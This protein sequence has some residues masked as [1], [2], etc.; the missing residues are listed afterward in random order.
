MDTIG[1]LEQKTLITKQCYS[2]KC[3]DE[4]AELDIKYVFCLF[5]F[6][7]RI[8]CVSLLNFETLIMSKLSMSFGS[9]RANL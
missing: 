5:L 7:F 2:L 8:A 3:R 1:D 6:L 4:S 9:V